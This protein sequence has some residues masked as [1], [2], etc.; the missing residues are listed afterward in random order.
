MAR[1]K[2][3]DHV[4]FYVKD[5]GIGVSPE[6]QR[7]LFSPYSQ[8][9][10]GT[11]RRFGGTGLGLAISQ[12]LAALMGGKIDMVSELGAGTTMIL[13][14]HLPIAD[15]SLLEPL[16]TMPAPLEM[17]A[18]ELG[19]EPD[20]ET[21][22]ATGEGALLLVVDDHP[23]NRML[24]MRQVTALGYSAES[25]VD[26]AEAFEKWKSGRFSLVL[27]DCNMPVMS[28]YELARAIR[29][30][31]SGTGARC[32]VLACTVAA[33][34]D[35][36]LHCIEAGMDAYLVKPMNLDTLMAGLKKWLPQASGA[37]ASLV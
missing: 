22:Q 19:A 24:L 16:E 14:L 29:E 27:T 5:T 31:E 20:D 10:L 17:A 25:A 32:P 18:A 37:Q 34:S 9:E 11:Q 2:G 12:R 33:M 13:D 26:G 36:V 28:G 7:R 23:S 1:G 8:A 3:R 21:H 35:E 15:A 30:A 6:N 4:R